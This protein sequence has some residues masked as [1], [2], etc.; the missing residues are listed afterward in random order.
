MWEYSDV[1]KR[2]IKIHSDGEEKPVWDAAQCH[3]IPFLVGEFINNHNKNHI[4][5][6]VVLFQELHQRGKHNTKSDLAKMTF[7]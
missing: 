3:A 4:Y 7:S 5:R 2:A 1:E 6:Q